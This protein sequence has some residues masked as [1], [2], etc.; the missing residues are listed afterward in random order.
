[1]DERVSLERTCVLI[2]TLLNF[3][4]SNIAKFGGDPNKVELHKVSPRML[5]DISDQITLFG[6]SAGSGSAALLMEHFPE[7]PPFHGAILDSG[8]VDG[9]DNIRTKGPIRLYQTRTDVGTPQ[10]LIRDGGRRDDAYLRKLCRGKAL[11]SSHCFLAKDETIGRFAKR[12]LR[13]G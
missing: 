13:A 5:V 8:V 3:R 7:D 2:S 4:L 6:Q 9:L 12:I 10:A 11:T 1:M